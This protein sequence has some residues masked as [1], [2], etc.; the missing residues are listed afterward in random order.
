[1]FKKK[2]DIFQTAIPSQEC[3]FKKINKYILYWPQNQNEQFACPNLNAIKILY[4]LRNY[5]GIRA[6][7]SSGIT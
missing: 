1:M 4:K 5:K 2:I 3:K 7:I 6:Q